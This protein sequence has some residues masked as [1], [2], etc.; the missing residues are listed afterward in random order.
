[1][2]I[3]NV[4][5]LINYGEMFFFFCIVT[6]GSCQSITS[7]KRFLPIDH[8]Y[9]KNKNDFFIGRVENDVALPVPSKGEMYDVISQYEGIVFDFQSGKQK[10]SGFDVT[11]NW[12]K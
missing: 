6:G 10:F 3:N 5:T 4:F 11:H 8:K 12:V 7:I 2:E 9:K 1:M